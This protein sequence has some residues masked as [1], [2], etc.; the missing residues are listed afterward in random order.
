MNFIPTNKFI[1]PVDSA[2]VIKNRVVAPENANLIVKN[3]EWEIP[4]NILQKNMIA[5]MDILANFNWDRPIYFAVTT[6]N[7]AYFGLEKYFQLEGL[8]YRLVPIRNDAPSE[9]LS[10]GRIN[11]NVLYNNLM[12]KFTWGGLNNPSVYLSEDNIRLTMTIRTIFG[13]LANSLISEN[14]IDSAL[15]VLDRAEEIMPNKL[16]PYNYFNLP[17]AE[18]YYR[19]GTPAAVAKGQAMLETLI[20]ICDSELTYYF[21]FKGS[22]KAGV[23]REIQQNLGIL[24]RLSQIAETYKADVVKKQADSIFEMSYTQWAQNKGNTR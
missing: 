8:A 15:K 5:M 11:T 12:N 13:R 1:L 10:L 9:D 3:I 23:D 4:D 6:G 16:V 21:R 18:A 19:I 7:D 20:K 22:M 24:Q 14:K 17:L 2:K